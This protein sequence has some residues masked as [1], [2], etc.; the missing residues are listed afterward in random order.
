MIS[1]KKRTCPEKGTPK[2]EIVMKEKKE[3]FGLYTVAMVGLMAALV[4]AGSKLEI[5]I[6][7]ILG[8]TRIHLGNSMCLLSGFLLGTVPGGI[9]AGLGSFLFD[10]IFWPGTP[11]DWLITF[12]TKFAMGAVAGFLAEKRPLGHRT[13]VP[14]FVLYG[15][16]GA[17]TYVVLYLLQSFVSFYFVLGNPMP[18]VLVML[19]EKGLTSLVNAV[20]AVVIAVPCYMALWPKLVRSGLSVRK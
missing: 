9:A 2:G 19:G 13:S 11:V 15:A 1:L 17:L 5:R 8:V 10:V 7:A 3:A 4:F 18:A 6:P 14:A 12:C 16:A 20:I